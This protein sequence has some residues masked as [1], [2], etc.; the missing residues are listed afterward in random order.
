VAFLKLVKSKNR[1]C[2]VKP[3]GYNLPVL[4]TTRMEVGVIWEKKG[5]SYLII[6]QTHA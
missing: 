3:N 4:V 1:K 6:I 5:K 2:F